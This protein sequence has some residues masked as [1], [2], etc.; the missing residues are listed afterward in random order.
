MSGSLDLANDLSGSGGD[1][2]AMMEGA[3]TRFTVHSPE[4]PD[5]KVLRLHKK[6]MR[7]YVTELGPIVLAGL[8]V[9]VVLICCLVILVREGSASADC[10]NAWKAII[11]VLGVVVGTLFG[12]A[13]SK[14][15][16]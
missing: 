7:F 16:A 14:S 15:A 9:T 11:G 3:K 8:I 13:T 6:K 2:L 5:N 10:E 4:D 12:R 1:A